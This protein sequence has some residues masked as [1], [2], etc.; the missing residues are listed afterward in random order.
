MFPEPL[1]DPAERTRIRWGTDVNRLVHSPVTGSLGRFET[2]F[3]P[4][5][6]M[7]RR[8]KPKGEEMR[9]EPR[10]GDAAIRRR[11]FVH[12]W[13]WPVPVLIVVAFIAVTAL[14]GEAHRR[15]IGRRPSGRDR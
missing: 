4:R 14:L 9:F 12:G 6:G 10:K 11:V 1:T 3:L 15:R 2:V 5:I 7:A 13:L 8:G